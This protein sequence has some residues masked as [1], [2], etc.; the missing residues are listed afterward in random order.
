MHYI[1]VVYLGCYV[2]SF[3][4]DIPQTCPVGSDFGLFTVRFVDYNI[5]G[6]CVKC[7]I[8]SRTLERFFPVILYAIDRRIIYLRQKF[9]RRMAGRRDT[10]PPGIKIL[11][12]PEWVVLF[13]FLTA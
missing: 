4:K 12:P 8:V 9:T 11:K 1:A 7:W 3:G 10:S 5:L 13:S 2:V 6:P